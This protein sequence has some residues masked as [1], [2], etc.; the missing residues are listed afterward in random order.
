MLPAVVLVGLAFVSVTPSMSTARTAATPAAARASVSRPAAAAR[1]AALVRS[2]AAATGSPCSA[3]LVALTFDDGPDP[4]VTPQLVHTLL[5]LRVPATFFMIGTHVDAHPTV[6]RLVQSKGFTIGNHTWNHP[7]LTHLSNQAVRDQLLATSSAF[8]RHYI[9]P[10]HLMR[11]PYG[12]IDDRVRTVVRELGMVPVL[13]TIDSR[14]WAGGDAVTIAHRILTALRPHGT[15]L[16]LQHD[17]V[18]NSPASLGAVPIVVRRGRERGYCF[19]HLSS[20]GGVGGS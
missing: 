19:T 1:P 12:D 15:N 5:S 9:K 6:A 7:M 16:V 20:T 8:K 11:P 14:D 17:G 4:T 13:W 10:S 2:G 18:A 3:G